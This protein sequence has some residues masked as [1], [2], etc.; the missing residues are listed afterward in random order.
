MVQAQ[1]EAARV[2]G[3]EWQSRIPDDLPVMAFDPDR[4]AQALGNLIHNAI[5]FTPQ[6]GTIAIIAGKKANQAWVEIRDNGPG[7]P[8]E[9]QELVFTPFFRGRAEIRFP[10]GMG[11]GLS[12]ARDLVMAHQGKLEVESVP[13]EGSS[14]TIWLPYQST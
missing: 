9:D 4:L 13:G 6:G 3:L 14:F 2:K 7:I 12:I 11:L 8:V 5:K 1:R 10:Q